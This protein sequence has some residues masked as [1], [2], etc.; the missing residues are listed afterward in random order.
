M[1]VLFR[2]NARS[3]SLPLAQEMLT[4]LIKYFHG[5]HYNNI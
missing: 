2:N 1:Q 4:A 5:G 3:I